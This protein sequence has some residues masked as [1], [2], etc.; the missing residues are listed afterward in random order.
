MKSSPRWKLVQEEEVSFSRS[1]LHLAAWKSDLESIEV[2]IHAGNR[3]G[4]DLVNAIV[5]G[6]GNYGK[7]GKFFRKRRLSEQSIHSGI[8]FQ[9]S[10]IQHSKL[11]SMPSTTAEIMLSDVY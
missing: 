3:F 4:L 9:A 5:T 6:N 2:L 8:N 7:T 11:F 1:P 10:A